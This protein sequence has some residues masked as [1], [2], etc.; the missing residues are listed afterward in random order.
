MQETILQIK[1]VILGES[2][3]G[4]SSVMLRFV[5]NNFKSDSAPTVGASYMGKTMQI[6]DKSIKFNIW[7]TAGQE[8]YHSLAKMY[9]HDANAALLLYDITSESSFQAM[10]RWYL[11]LKD[12][13]LD[14]I[15]VCICG[16]KEDLIAN[17]AV[18]PEDARNYAKSIGAFY[19]KT[20]AK[21]SL[22]IE[23]VFKEIA[24]RIFSDIEPTS[25]NH[26]DSIALE[27]KSNKSVGKKGCC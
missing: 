15:V 11:E 13:A 10:K 20:S 22:G 3:V 9:L 16:N 26:K 25:Y 12:V 27:R 5:T 24:Q 14:N 19:K 21:T 6:S 23:N 18:S 2:G 7:D 17:E 8:R 1:V 4:K